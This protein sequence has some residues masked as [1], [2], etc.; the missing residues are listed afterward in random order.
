LLPHDFLITQKTTFRVTIAVADGLAAGM[1]K[2]VNPYNYARG[3][4]DQAFLL[5]MGRTDPSYTVQE[6]E[7]LHQLITSP[8]KELVL[9]ESGH[10]L[11]AAHVEKAVAWI[12]D[13]L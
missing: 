5:L 7:K 9:Y 4:R 8:T 12:K 1:P 11:P 10:R 2:I 3:I 13:H 6:A